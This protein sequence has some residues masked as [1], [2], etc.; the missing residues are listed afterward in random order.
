MDNFEKEKIYDLIKKELKKYIENEER[1]ASK[2][3]YEDV[4]LELAEKFV[5]EA[6]KYAKE[7]SL[8]LSVSVV[9]K[10]GNLVLFKRTDGAIIASIDVSMKKAYTALLLNSPTSKVDLVEFPGL[11]RIFKEKLVTFGGGYPIVYEGR[12][13]GALGVSGGSSVDDDEIARKTV[14]SIVEGLCCY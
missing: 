9:D 1:I 12:L 10:G 7:K 13:I 3:N 2:K 5:K 11:D 4:N 6:L 8:N 14:E